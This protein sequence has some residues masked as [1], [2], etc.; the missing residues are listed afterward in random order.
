MQKNHCFDHPW[1]V[2][3]LERKE[4]VNKVDKNK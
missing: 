2:N 1:S 3:D 4:K